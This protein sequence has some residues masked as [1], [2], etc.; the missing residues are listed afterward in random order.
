LGVAQ[1]VEVGGRGHWRRRRR[2]VV[3]VVV[4]WE[5]RSGRSAEQVS[6]QVESEEREEARTYLRSGPPELDVRSL[7]AAVGLL[8]PPQGSSGRRR[9]PPAATSC[10]IYKKRYEERRGEEKS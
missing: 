5:G 9:T 2:G 10:K 8:R 1:E 4:D 3:V 7:P 6:E